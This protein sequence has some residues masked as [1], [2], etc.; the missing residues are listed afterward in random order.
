MKKLISI[1]LAVMIV[2]TVFTALPFT[3]SAATIVDSGTTGDCTWTLDDEGTLTISGNGA[4][5]GY[6]YWDTAP[7]G[8]DIKKVVIE[9]GV[10]NIGDFAFKGC[11]SLTSIMI[12]DSVTSIDEYAFSRSTNLES[13]TI[14]DSV[15]SIGIC[16]FK[17]CTSLTS[18][19]IPDSVTSIGGGA[20]S[21]CTSL[22]SITIPD[23]V[24]SIDNEAFY[25]TA[26]YKYQ[27]DGL[28]YAGKVAYKYKGKM[29]ENTSI[30]IKDGTKGI[31]S[32]A[33]SDCTS[34]ESITIP[35]SVTS[36]AEGTF[37]YCTSLTSVT[38][39]DNVMSIGDSA[40][41]KCTSL[42]SVTIPDSVTSIGEE[43]F[44]KCTSLKSITIPD[45]VTSIGDRAFGYYYDN[46][47]NKIKV[48]G[49][50][51]YGYEGSEA[52]RYANDNGFRF[53]EKVN[54]QTY[55]DE[56]TDISVT[57]NE[58]LSLKVIEKSAAEAGDIVLG[59]GEAIN[60]VFD[61]SLLKDGA[62][63][64]PEGNVTVKI[65]CDN[66]GAK[67][68]RVEQDNSLTDMNAVYENGYLIF[69]TDHFSVYVVSVPKTYTIGDSNG[70]GNVDVLD[71]AAIQKFASGM[72]DM[73]NNQQYFAD[74]NNDGV[75]DIL[76]ADEIQKF[77]AGIITEFK[78]KG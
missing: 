72:A 10:S 61:I 51:V 64:Q 35:D 46:N 59:Q 67:V 16:A 47:W 25:N 69:T 57:S 32:R 5:G 7:W 23:S 8:T 68:Y 77:A 53:V 73:T 38:I 42:E 2:A 31:A 66:D 60:S 43:A 39:P 17:G 19:T 58:G 56:E 62:E 76:D 71:A 14:G 49:F 75:V 33:F 78:K 52:E 12:P 20:F 54:N 11:T 74:V 18:I 37:I 36:I 28:V 34:L 29:P 44:C 63:V 9:N 48:D 26:W 27:P 70:D 1:L 50:T 4:M 13:V 6:N 22:E 40:F 3:V 55:T 24:M 30:V 15:T 41:Y 21:D 45:S 65:P